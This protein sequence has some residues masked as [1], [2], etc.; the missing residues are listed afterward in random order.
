M[1]TEIFPSEIVADVVIQTLIECGVDHFFMLA[2]GN[3]MFLNDAVRRSRIT[4]TAFHHEQAAA[5]AADAYARTSG[6]LAACLVTSGPGVSNLV[7]GAAGA[8]LDS[9]SVFFIAGQAK[10]SELVTESMKPGV[11]QFGTFELPGVELM[12]PVCKVS[13]LLKNSDDPKQVVLDL[14]QKSLKG[15]P[16]PVFLEIPLDVQ[17][18]KAPVGLNVQELVSEVDPKLE[19]D[20]FLNEFLNAL[21]VSERPIVL[22]GYGV[23]A[24]KK[25]QEFRNFIVKLGLPVV[26]TQLAKQVLPYDSPYFVGHVGLRGDRPG[27]IAT[28][29]SDCILVIGSSLQQ[30]TVGYE[31][32]DF[33]PNSKIFVVDFEKSITSKKLPLEFEMTL[34]CSVQEFLSRAKILD[35]GRIQLVQR[36]S[37][38]SHTQ[39]LKHQ[40][41]V[42]S[43]PH[44]TGTRR[45]NLYDFAEKLSL[46]TLPSDIVVAD[47]GLSF[48]VMGQAFRIADTQQYLVSGG[49]GAM[50]YALPAA[51]GAAHTRNGR[52]IA[53]TGD[54]SMQMNIQEMATLAGI[55]LPIIVF[56]INNEGYAS[57][58]NS[59]KSFFGEELI[60]SSSSSGVRMPDWSIISKAYGVEYLKIEN[61]T[62]L[63]EALLAL[64]EISSP[65]V[66]EVMCQE[67]QQIMPMIASTRNSEGKLVSN[68]LHVMS[69]LNENDRELPQQN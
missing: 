53:V 2:G 4:Y 12:K 38:L 64:K 36:A 33:A 49:L 65:I 17:N 56:V 48:Y 66:V 3:A 26:T 37:W 45:I 51:I 62:Q 1:K 7:T 25:V 11:R 6:K 30:Q 35:S 19:I 22:A 54:G 31:P 69:P 50:G 52:V 27:N 21:A 29:E 28:F 40:K 23:V 67:N 15:R 5:M 32:K 55:Q 14:V 9:S 60:A 18:S 44:E 20:S 58:R 42:A 46:A 24:S 10:I 57:I 13:R 61:A 41:S 16:G 59:Q 68:P 8:F 43:E 47:A 39:S 63:A 34:D